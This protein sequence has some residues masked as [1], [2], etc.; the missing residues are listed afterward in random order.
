MISNL[1]IFL[2][3]LW[4][5][6]IIIAAIFNISIIFPLEVVEDKQI[7]QERLVSIRLALFATFAYYGISHL[8][9]K[10]KMFLSNP[11]LMYFLIF[12]VIYGRYHLFTNE[13]I[14]GFCLYSELVTHFF[15]FIIA[16]IL[17]LGSTPQYKRI[18]KKINQYHKN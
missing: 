4:A 1:I 15:W 12:F 5:I 17:H 3:S 10:N 13:I 18:F 11:F 7:P 16:A 9:N 14:W 6:W 8:L 2:L